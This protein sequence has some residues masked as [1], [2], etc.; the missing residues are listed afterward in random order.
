MSGSLAMIGVP[1]AIAWATLS[2]V[3]GGPS[4]VPHILAVEILRGEPTTVGASWIEHR[5]YGGSKKIVMRKTM[6]SVDVDPET[7]IRTVHMVIHI[8]GISWSSPDAVETCSISVAPLMGPDDED[9]QQQQQQQQ[10]CTVSWTMA[11]IGAGVW[12]TLILSM[13]W[14]CIGRSLQCQLEE[15]LRYYYDEALRRTNA[16]NKRE[17][18]AAAPL[19]HGRT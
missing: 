18:E 8:E 3:E 11:Y 2:D 12:G 16:A 10:S 14:S 5:L 4:F 15:E 13:F 6:T 9:E 7:G 17:E 19:Y 1:V